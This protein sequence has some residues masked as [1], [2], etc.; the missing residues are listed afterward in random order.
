MEFSSKKLL[1]IFYFS[2]FNSSKVF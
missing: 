1:E 2:E